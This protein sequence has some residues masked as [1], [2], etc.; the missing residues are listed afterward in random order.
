MLGIVQGRLSYAGRKLQCF[1]K[2]PFKEFKLASNIGYEFIEFFGERIKN[3]KNPLWSN[4][5]INKYLKFSKENNIKIY[6]FC[7]DYVINHSLTSSKTLEQIFNTLERL[8]IL[9][10]KKYILP[11]YGKS[12]FN[13]KNKINI[14]A[15][16]S[17]ISKKCNKLGIQLLIESNM[18][19]Y[20]FKKLKKSIKCQNFFFVFDTGNRIFLKRSI[21]Q[22]ILKFADDIKH[23]HLKD[24][25][26][27]N[28]NVIIGNG[29]VNFK[30]IFVALK[31]I[32]YNKSFAIES[33]RGQDIKRQATKNFNFFYQLIKQYKSK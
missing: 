29:I 9:K 22:D 3:N 33:Q 14:Y 8:K 6:S 32:G 30:S 4:T 23:V 25:N 5:G 24:K 31:K 26:I 17:K 19:P 12:N 16:L 11:L 28:K 20:Q 18:S 7:D 1:P 15:N 13:L 2:K 27:K 21:T 10:V